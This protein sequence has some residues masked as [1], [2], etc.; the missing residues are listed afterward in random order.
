MVEPAV[1]VGLWRDYSQD[2]LHQPTLTLPLSVGG[3][4]ASGLTLLVS[5][6][7]ACTW[8]IAAYAIHQLRIRHNQSYDPLHLQIQSLL[9]NDV[10]AFSAISDAFFLIQAWFQTPYNVIR[11][12]VPIVLVAASILILF[13]LA[14]VFVS[15]VASRSEANV[16]VLAQPGDCGGWDI[17]W[18]RVYKDSARKQQASPEMLKVVANDTLNARTYAKLF[19]AEVPAAVSANSMF[20][21]QKLPYS[22]RMEPCPFEG[23][24]RCISNDTLSPNTALT[25]DSGL[26][27]SHI[28]LGVNAPVENRV[29]IRKILTCSPIDVSDFTEA[30]PEVDG[31]TSF[32]LHKLVNQNLTLTFNRHRQL[33][34]AGYEASCISWSAFQRDVQWPALALQRTDADITICYVAQNSV[35][36][37]A[38]VYDPFF[39]A[40][41]SVADDSN[42]VPVYWGSNLFNAIACLEQVQF[43]NPNNE[44]CT[45]ITH[46][47]GAFR[48]SSGL[49]LNTYQWTTVNRTAV[50]LGLTDIGWLG[51]DS[52]G[53]QGL[54]ARDFAFGDIFSAH[55]PSD[56]WQKE[57]K[58]WFATG[59]ALLQGHILRF[60]DRIDL[61]SPEVYG[62][63]LTHVP[64]DKLS[65]REREAADYNCH[66]QK[67]TTT[68]Q[69]QNF[70][71]LGVLIV[72]VSCVFI[73]LISLFLELTVGYVRR[74]WVSKDGQARQLA[75]EM[76]N[77]FW[78]LRMSLEGAGVSGW[79]RGGRKM[80]SSIP[81]M[82][83]THMVHPPSD[84]G[85]NFYQVKV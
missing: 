65:G 19:Y 73:I 47:E 69:F 18:T 31:L 7:G 61:S 6:A 22:V 3:F 28:H 39:W 12:L 63:Y 70:Q 8:T 41:G 40:N 29:N 53:G 10:T 15:A 78:L 82:E 1:Y 75:R 49:G 81:I 24:N 71:L 79:R 17:N 84:Y 30:L 77:Q 55:L 83:N 11:R 80:D 51:L 57:V 27:D 33:A 59:L 76:D 68:G 60:L 21:T 14:G 52:L 20:P 42:G 43:C 62:R 4:L 38:P 16:I 23:E 5:L 9:R 25:L 56:Q 48:Q 36:Y 37:V 58:L 32:D 54:L 74:Y 44:L 35:R 26:L 67:I 64:L 85:D 72:I 50:L 66:N 2:T 34:S 13:S 45:N 46:A